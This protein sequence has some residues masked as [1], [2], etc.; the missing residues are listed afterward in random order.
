MAINQVKIKQKVPLNGYFQQ[1]WKLSLSCMTVFLTLFF[2]SLSPYSGSQLGAFSLN[3]TV[4]ENIFWNDM[5]VSKWQN[6]HFWVNYSFKNN[7]CNATWIYVCVDTLR[8]WCFSLEGVNMRKQRERE[9]MR[10]PHSLSDDTISN[11]LQVFVCV[12]LCVCV[13]SLN[14]E[15]A[16]GKLWYSSQDGPALHHRS[17]STQQKHILFRFIQTLCVFVGVYFSL[18]HLKSNW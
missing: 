8:A 14:V 12:S 2:F 3:L 11:L 10:E 15:Q 16:T 7:V 4:L 9:R 6:I 17:T 13:C 5:M 1:K 18:S